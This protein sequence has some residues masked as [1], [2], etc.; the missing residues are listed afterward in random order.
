MFLSNHAK[1][2][3]AKRNIS[4]NEISACLKYGEK[5][6]RSGVCFSVLLEKNLRQFCLP[7]N[8]NGLCVLT[9]KDNTIITVYKSKSAYSEIK[10]LSK[11]DIKKFYTKH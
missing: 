8:L 5:I 3:M 6:H 7:N 9:A 1:E 11:M 10:K 4:H 2:R